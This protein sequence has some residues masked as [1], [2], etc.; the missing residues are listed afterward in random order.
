MTMDWDDAYRNGAYIKGGDD[1]PALWQNRAAQYRLHMGRAGRIRPDLPYGS[2]ARQKLDL[3]LPESEPLGLVMIVHGGYW[4]ETDK[5]LW[6]H[7]AA[8]AVAAGWAVA[9]PSYRLAPQARISAITADVAAALDYAAKLVPGPIRLTGHSAGGHLVGR[10]AS[11]SSGLSASVKDRLQHVMPISGLNDLR[12]LMKTSM[13]QLLQLDH[14]EALRESPALLEPLP[15]VRITCW[16]GAEERP[17]F[18]RQND[19]LANI[20]TGL[21]ANIRA[22]HDAGRHHYDVIEGL[23]QAE[24]PIV[25]ALLGH[26]GWVS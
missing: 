15:G 22:V 26:D 20:W 16:V 23:A 10:M 5:S 3:F 17:E 12:P 13:Q 21:G 4:I 1:Y 14:D 6:S 2:D 8:G 25:S 18:I 24:S 7:L 11:T 19:L 9:M